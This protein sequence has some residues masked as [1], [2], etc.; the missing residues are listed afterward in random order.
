MVGQQPSS[1]AQ[2]PRHSTP[3]RAYGTLVEGSDDSRHGHILASLDDLRA[4]LLAAA[5][6]EKSASLLILRTLNHETTEILQAAAGIDP[7]FVT[8]IRSGQAKMVDLD[9]PRHDE[10][11]GSGTGL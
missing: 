10:E 8:Q 3:V 7:G 5:D 1:L 9:I 2:Q 6:G 11:E 4:A